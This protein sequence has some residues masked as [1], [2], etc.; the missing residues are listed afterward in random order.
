MVRARGFSIGTLIVDLYRALFART[1]RRQTSPIPCKQEGYRMKTCLTTVVVS[2]T[3][4]VMLYGRGREGEGGGKKI[5]KREVKMIPHI[6]FILLIE[7]KT[8]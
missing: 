3:A 1:K 8:I 4:R 5:R 6:K 7:F 2:D